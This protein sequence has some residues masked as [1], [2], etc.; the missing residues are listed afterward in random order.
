MK[1]LF[2]L[3]VVLCLGLATVDAKK[4]FDAKYLH[5]MQG[6]TFF[7]LLYGSASPWFISL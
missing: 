7:D 4:E 1:S 2:V 6:D 5:L 3:C